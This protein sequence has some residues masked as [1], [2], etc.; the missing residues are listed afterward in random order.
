MAVNNTNTKMAIGICNHNATVLAA[1]NAVVIC[2]VP[3][4]TDDNASDESKAKALVRLK[5][6][7]PS[8]N[9]LRGFPINNRFKKRHMIFLLNTYIRQN[10]QK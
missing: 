5:C 6:C 10:A 7:E 8:S 4:A 9:V 3:Y 2:S 1:I